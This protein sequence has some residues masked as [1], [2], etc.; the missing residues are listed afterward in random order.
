L[1]KGDYLFN[2]I[3]VHGAITECREAPSSFAKKTLEEAFQGDTARSIAYLVILSTHQD[4]RYFNALFDQVIRSGEDLGLFIS[5]CRSGVVRSGLGSSVKSVAQEWLRRVPPE[6]IYEHNH[7]WKE[8]RVGW[9]WF[10]FLKLLRPKPNT[11]IE[12]SKFSYMSKA[13]NPISEEAVRRA[14]GGDNRILSRG[15]EQFILQEDDEMNTE[16]KLEELKRRIDDLED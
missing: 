6:E 10:D 16:E 3:D 15:N 1:G 8:G 9:G 13:R 7:K 14:I 11:P 4:K 12:Q 2:S 5:A